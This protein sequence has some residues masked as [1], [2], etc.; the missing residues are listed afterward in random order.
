MAR[1]LV[2]W[3]VRSVTLVDS[4]RV[5]YSNPTRQCLF[6]FEDGA[7]G[8]PKAEAAAAAL[9]AIFPDMRAEGRVL[10]IPMP[11]HPFAGSDEEVCVAAIYCLH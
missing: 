1:A 4:G 5:S 2:G 3:G 6:S 11:G 10:S 8:L 7:R 9:R